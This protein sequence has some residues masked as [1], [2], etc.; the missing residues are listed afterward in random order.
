MHLHRLLLIFGL[1]SAGIPTGC[2]SGS[3]DPRAADF[4]AASEVIASEVSAQEA[5]MDRSLM[6]K[7]LRVR[8]IDADGRPVTEAA[9][10]WIWRGGGEGR[11]SA[12]RSKHIGSGQFAVW[13]L[14]TPV[15]Y[16]DTHLLAMVDGQ[17]SAVSKPLNFPL[18]DK[19]WTLQLPP[20]TWLEIQATG[21]ARLAGAGQVTELASNMG[22]TTHYQGYWPH[23]S[24]RSLDS[25]PELK[26][27]MS[28]EE[29]LNWPEND[30]LR[31]EALVPGR[32]VLESTWYT[33]I[34]LSGLSKGT[35]HRTTSRTELQISAGENRLT[36]PLPEAGSLELDCGEDSGNLLLAQIP[37]PL[38]PFELLTHSVTI[39]E[40][41]VARWPVLPLGRYLILH[42]DT[43]LL[44]DFTGEPTSLDSL[45][46]AGAFRF[47]KIEAGGGLARAGFQEGDRLLTVRG[48]EST[49]LAVTTMF[50]W[51]LYEAE[52]PVACTIERTG[53]HLELSLDPKGWGELGPGG[54]INVEPRKP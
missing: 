24:I 28:L 42:T 9:F 16:A 14:E 26:Q 34:R 13:P 6:E 10:E 40:D 51:N 43:P 27:S 5:A 31:F 49:P 19:D 29:I 39:E 2:N 38:Q 33:D 36:A 3:G 44:L 32:Y 17:A 1:A 25:T 30:T 45:S 12:R 41:G 50:R 53:Q 22:P 23:F 7:G 35:Q 37:F 54:V 11:S 46:E 8:L 48:E 18:D 47:R 52:E 15:P 4:D 21:G 20:E